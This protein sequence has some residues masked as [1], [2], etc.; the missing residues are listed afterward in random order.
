VLGGSA[1]LN[2]NKK[3]IQGTA[4]TSLLPD[5]VRI[6]FLLLVKVTFPP[7]TCY[8]ANLQANRMK[9]FRT[10]RLVPSKYGQNVYILKHLASEVQMHNQK[11]KKK[12]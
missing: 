9:C 5:S 3:P 4:V 2:K 10:L 6:N 11:K 8:P 1:V 7:C 12:E